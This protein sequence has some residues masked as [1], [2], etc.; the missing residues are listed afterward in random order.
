MHLSAIVV[1]F[2]KE[3]M[4]AECLSSLEAALARV[5]G[6]TELIVVVN[7][8]TPGMVERLHE[9]HG[10]IVAI[11]G[12]ATLGFAGAV[13]AGLESARGEWVALVN[14][15]CSVCP[16]ALEELL[17]VGSLSRDVGSVA[18]QI[19]FAERPGTLN[20]AGIELDELGVARERCLGEPVAAVEP[21]PVAVAGASG[22]FGLYRREMLDSVGGLDASFFAYLEDADLAWRARMAGWRCLLAPRA[23]AFHHHSATLGHGSPEKYALVGRNRVRMLAKNATGRQL[24]RELLRIV[25]YDLAYVGYVAVTA[26]TLGPLAGRVRGLAEWSAYRAAGDGGRRDL[27]FTPAPGL[28]AA[29]RRNRVYRSARSPVG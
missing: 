6:G 29:L 9:R 25:G 16:D 13:Q 15:D 3:R 17:A 11:E 5:E 21:G 27:G 24:R 23:I 1:A 12:D 2:G 19:R 28:R 22:T 7:D 10:R 4:L 18:A 8:G 20:S 26:R 14:D